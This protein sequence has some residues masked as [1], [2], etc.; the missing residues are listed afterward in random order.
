[1]TGGTGGTEG[2]GGVGGTSMGGGVGG[3]NVDAGVQLT[4]EQ[5]ALASLEGHYLMRM[6]MFSTTT[7]RALLNLNIAT[8]N[9]ISHLLAT[10]LYVDT[11]GQLK[12]YERLCYQ[13]FEHKCTQGCSSVTT[14][15]DGRMTDFFTKMDYTQR[16][17]VLSNGMLTGMSNTMPLGFDAK[18][19]ARLPTV[20]DARVWDPAPGG[21]REGLL[22]AL[23]LASTLKNVNCDVYTT[24]IFVSKLAT[25]K[26]AGSAAAPSLE[27]PQF[28]LD[29]QGSDGKTLG[30]NQT[31]C[32]DDGM[33]AAPVEG[34]QY[35]RFAR[36][37]LNSVGGEQAFW[38]CPEQSAWDN[39]AMLRPP[40]P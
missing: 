19:D 15:M 13:T 29:T 14:R 30:S 7:V 4:P 23:S 5:M 25:T 28:K 11:S 20:E 36:I 2:G 3:G 27:G 31:D 21:K 26:L 39:N 40:A 22:L 24:Q 10:Q 6:D 32:E 17:Y 8:S 34:Q 18:T 38:N 33:G 37:D 9:R 16:S 35:V 12:G 1:M